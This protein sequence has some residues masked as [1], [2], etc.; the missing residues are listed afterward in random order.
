MT[1]LASI[2]SACIRS[3]MVLLLGIPAMSTGRSAWAA[4]TTA[5]V[6]TAIGILGT[7]LQVWTD[8]Y[9]RMW[10]YRYESAEST[11][12]F[13]KQYYTYYSP[14]LRVTTGQGTVVCG[15][16]QT[17][18][19]SFL[20][21]PDAHTKLNP[22]NVLSEV[23]TAGGTIRIVHNL[24]YVDGDSY[25]L[26]TWF[27]TNL[28]VETYTNLALRYGGDTYF[29][30]RD[31]ARGEFDTGTNL[32]YCLNPDEGI[33]GLMGMQA[34]PDSPASSFYEGPYGDV[35]ASL[36]STANMPNSFTTEFLDNGMAVE[37]RHPS[38]ASGESFTVMLYEKWTDA[39]A[40]QVLAPAPFVALANTSPSTT[41]RVRNLLGTSGT[42]SAV[43]VNLSLSV[44]RGWS[45]D[46]PKSPLNIP[47][48]GVVDVPIGFTIPSG[49]A[50]GLYPISLEIRDVETGG[51]THHHSAAVTVSVTGEA[52]PP[53]PVVSLPTSASLPLSTEERTVYTAINPCTPEGI[54]SVLAAISGR[55]RTITRAFAWD[56]YQGKYIELPDSEV[57]GYLSNGVATSTGIFIATRR[58]LVYDLSGS[59]TAPPFEITVVNGADPV[60][61]PG[62]S[63]GWTFAGLPP[64][65]TA[66]EVYQT[67]FT[68]PDSF[69]IIHNGQSITATS[70][71]YNLQQLMGDPASPDPETSRPWHWN[72]ATYEQTTT[73]TCGEAYWFKNNDVSHPI[74]IRIA[75][76]TPQVVALRS[77]SAD[78]PASATNPATPPSAPGA[79]A[80]PVLRDRG[81]P[82]PPPSDATT[83]ASSSAGGCGTGSGIASF[84]LLLF[85][86]SLRFLVARR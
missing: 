85:A 15:N 30:N 16:H 52:E 71:P 5:P 14:T 77:G 79:S 46:P 11:P 25:F 86:F 80:A 43:N 2:S 78:A 27:V 45:F 13:Y 58:P 7:P 76:F 19:Y 36:V 31:S 26:H 50:N 60:L 6:P 23:T 65:E 68:W 61:N 37:W 18:P 74:T 22:S 38:L 66:P 64:I 40:V 55:P 9:L 69:E 56:N 48:N 10:A 62:T 28:G 4:D 83:K 63:S 59:P 21:T 8:E 24:T 67:D 47:A 12:D 17:G 82:P 53:P 51:E 32:L 49:T 84:A 57:V 54:D 41:F 35:T 75:G 33:T 72:G 81:T 34:S 29:A 44:P 70:T 1:A 3:V 73:L 39:G 20:P 42:G